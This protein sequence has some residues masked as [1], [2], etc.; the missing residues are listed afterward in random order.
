[1]NKV[2]LDCQLTRRKTFHILYDQDGHEVWRS[3]RISELLS[4]ARGA[5]MT[6]IACEFIVTPGLQP[7]E[8]IITLRS[9]TNG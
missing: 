8:A 5:S 6:E 9:K 2:V 1:M 4:V 3:Q 7:F